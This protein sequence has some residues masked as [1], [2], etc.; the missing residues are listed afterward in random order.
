L[1]VAS[2]GEDHIQIPTSSAHSLLVWIKSPFLGSILPYK[3][4]IRIWQKLKSIVQVGQKRSLAAH[5]QEPS[6][7]N[8]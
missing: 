7:I 4:M 3:M 6:F 5:E 1:K 2:L 8:S